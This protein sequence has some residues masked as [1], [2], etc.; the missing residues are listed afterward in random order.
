MILI[1]IIRSYAANTY[2]NFPYHRVYP[3]SMNI[4]E[5]RQPLRSC[6]NSPGSLRIFNFS[7]TSLYYD[8]CGKVYMGKAV[9]QCYTIRCRK[10]IH[11][12]VWNRPCWMREWASRCPARFRHEYTFKTEQTV[13]QNCSVF[14]YWS[15]AP[16]PT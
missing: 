10:R 8:Y 1:N 12:T 9:A 5:M 16:H 6:G 7:V 3:L 15:C 14:T 2:V 4:R 13:V 11:R